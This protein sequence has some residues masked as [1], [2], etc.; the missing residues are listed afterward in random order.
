M[1]ESSVVND[2]KLTASAILATSADH[3]VLEDNAN[4]AF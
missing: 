1:A 2:F 3:A 4:H